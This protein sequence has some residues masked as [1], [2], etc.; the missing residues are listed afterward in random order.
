MTP[1][2]LTAYHEAAHALLGI[3]L[4]VA[5]ESITIDPDRNPGQKGSV[6]F[7]KHIAD[8]LL[9]HPVSYA[10]M[11][12]AGSVADEVADPNLNVYD[13][14]LR[15][16]CDD[17]KKASTILDVYFQFGGTLPADDP[18][19]VEGILV[20]RLRAFFQTPEVWR[21]AGDLAKKLLRYTTITGDE[22]YRFLGRRSRLAVINRHSRLV[23]TD[24]E[25]RAENLTH[26]GFQ[27]GIAAKGEPLPSA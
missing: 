23:V 14:F 27:W 3:R 2:E 11:L 21:V 5:V 9:Y 19:I 10:A 16:G 7:E 24:D 12:L 4:G 18:I 15:G 20:H 8:R 22:F 13:L 26:C 1:R 25:Y 6:C 17:Y